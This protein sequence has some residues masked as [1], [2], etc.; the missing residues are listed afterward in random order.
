[1][2]IPRNR[3]ECGRYGEKANVKVC[4]WMQRSLPVSAS[5]WEPCRQLPWII[6]LKDK[7][8]KHLPISSCAPLFESCHQ[9]I[10]SAIL[11]GFH[12]ISGAGGNPRQKVRRHS[13]LKGSAG[14]KSIK[15]HKKLCIQQRLTSEDWEGTMRG[16][17]FLTFLLFWTTVAPVY[18]LVKAYWINGLTCENMG[19]KEHKLNSGK[20]KACS[21]FTDWVSQNR[22]A[23][24]REAGLGIRKLGGAKSLARQSW[25]SHRWWEAPGGSFFLI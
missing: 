8:K 22:E 3:K 11:P 9:N 14:T 19:S 4:F 16:V 12:L 7:K 6:S 10:S 5:S 23:C 2:V 18:R 15:A 25:L 13:I 20:G 1:M 21:V 17:A 24:G